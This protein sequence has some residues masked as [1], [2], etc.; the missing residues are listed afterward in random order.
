MPGIE[1]QIS[2]AWRTHCHPFGHS[3]WKKGNYFA[4]A[5][6]FSAGEVE[7]G[8]LIQLISALKRKYGL[9]KFPFS[10]SISQLLILGRNKF[11]FSN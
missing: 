7:K 3:K 9:I 1:F 4:C 10:T 8:Q 6:N 11:T 2:V 5:P